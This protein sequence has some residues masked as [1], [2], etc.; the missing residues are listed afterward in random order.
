MLTSSTTTVI[1]RPAADVFAAVADI[2]RMGEW[3]PECTAGR[4][5]APATGPALGAQFEGDNIA[6]VGPITLKKWTTTAE[7][8]ECVPNQVFEFFAEGYTTW[9]YEFVER[10]GSTSVTESCSYAPSEGWKKFAYETV[11]R[12][13]QMVARG[14]E[15]TLARLK[16]ALER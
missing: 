8:T 7:V 5:V 2:T 4:W 11:L 16:T 6:K 1:R 14:M 15:Q 3:S 13:P 9:R 10:D 12:R